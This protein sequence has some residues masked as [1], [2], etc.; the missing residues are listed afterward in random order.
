[1]GTRSGSVSRTRVPDHL[2]CL[3]ICVAGYLN[4]SMP[5]GTSR[6]VAPCE[7]ARPPCKTLGLFSHVIRVDV[8]VE[9][10]SALTINGRQAKAPRLSANPSSTCSAG[11]HRPI[12]RTRDSSTRSNASCVLDVSIVPV[13]RLPHSLLRKRSISTSRSLFSFNVR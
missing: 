1:V 10:N 6:C 5:D 8:H 13:F 3:L 2:N 7:M 9:M 12:V 11:F 4:T